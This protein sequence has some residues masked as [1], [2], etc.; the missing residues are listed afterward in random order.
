MTGHRWSIRVA[1]ICVL[2]AS[3]VAVPA[4]QPQQQPE[5]AAKS[6]GETGPELR[7]LHTELFSLQIPVDWTE[8]A[9]EELEAVRQQSEG[10]GREI[11]PPAIAADAPLDR[12]VW[13][14]AF[15]SPDGDS[16]VMLSISEI[17]ELEEPGRS[18]IERKVLGYAD[19][20]RARGAI[21]KIRVA[22]TEELNGLPAVEVV[23][24]LPLGTTLYT[25]NV[26]TSVYKNRVGTIV[27]VANQGALAETDKA[28]TRMLA[29]LQPSE[30]VR[31]AQEED[32]LR[33][34]IRDNLWNVAG[35]SDSRLLIQRTILVLTTFTLFFALTLR[36]L[37]QTVVFWYRAHNQQDKLM[38]MARQAARDFL[39]LG[40]A[41]SQRLSLACALF[42]MSMT[43][44]TVLW[45]SAP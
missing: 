19:W 10:I 37:Y 40:M 4:S 14:N 16:R 30:Q 15:D 25:A 24:D 3:A 7:W 12:I 27:A 1:A 23:L 20:H 29:S 41:Y 11:F 32:T 26:W 17:P 42:S 36:L 22:E 2:V 43:T 35:A 18:Y 44:V 5:A 21:S 9:G 31:K 28:F 38:E 33:R 8:V 13:L 39:R 45:V 6:E 34:W